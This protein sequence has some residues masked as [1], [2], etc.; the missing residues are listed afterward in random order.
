[1]TMRKFCVALLSAIIAASPLA[2]GRGA[3]GGGAPT[4]FSLPLL[5]AS[6]AAS[7]FTF[8]GSITIP[9]G[10]N[11]YYGGVVSPGGALSVSGTTAF[12][13][14]H[15]CNPTVQFCNSYA[16]GVAQMTLPAPCAGYSGGSACTATVVTPPQ[17]P[18]VTYIHDYTFTQ[19][20]VAGD[21][22][23]TFTSLPPNI[24]ANSGWYL[25]FNGTTTTDE[26]TAISGNT[27]TWATALPS[28]TYSTTI[29]VYQ[30]SPTEP[31]CNPG[32]NCAITGS[33][34]VN[35]TLYVTGAATYDLGSGTA[36]WVVQSS[37]PISGS[38]WGAIN[39]PLVG[40][41][42][43]AIYSRYLAGPLYQTPSIWQPYFGQDYST[44]GNGLSI[45]SEDVPQGPSY[46]AFN[47][48]DITSAGANT[49]I[50]SVLL[51]NIG[52]NT[53]TN[54]SYSGPFPTCTQS[55][56]C[57]PSASGYPITLSSTPAAGDTSETIALPTATVTATANISSATDAPN[58]TITAITAGT[59]SDSAIRYTVTDT[60]GVL[61][62]GT[63]A[64]PSYNYAPGTTLGTGTY[65][66]G[67]PTAAATSDTLT[68]TPDG[69]NNTVGGQTTG[70]S[71]WTITFS[72]GERR[73]GTI[74]S[75]TI[76]FSP[77]LT[78]T[79]SQ[80]AEIAPM[81]DAWNTDYDGPSGTGFWV[82]GTSTFLAM[83]YHHE[84][85]LLPRTA[86]DPCAGASASESFYA[87]A[88]DTGQNSQVVMLLYSASDLYKQVTNPSTYPP[89]TAKPYATVEFPDN[90]HLFSSNG[91]VPNNLQY[92]NSW[93]SFDPSDDKFYAATNGSDIFEY[94]V[95][96]P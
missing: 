65:S 46:Q 14:G 59:L 72:D 26:V 78:G 22:Q 39:I 42:A 34:V 10:T 57:S 90:S 83:Y 61:P 86:A 67:T 33:M 20:P 52:N 29:P 3:R 62:S 96:P 4:P 85:P 40:G 94:T 8:D 18:G 60:A 21:T 73:V 36:G 66:I 1:M 55:E 41:T 12:I 89:Y 92:Q 54:S 87:L 56:T 44:N 28:G 25:D 30:F 71:V 75:S 47:T 45:V 15:A 80:S 88:P 7:M 50:T 31:W 43:N 64:I 74:S 17:V 76:T 58:V 95:T 68:F 37:L 84:G 32:N 13:N 53:L 79:P 9:T 5:T 69:Y 51:Y 11:T 16:L 49:P 23:A 77:A 6:Q 70:E 27:V 81:G 82:P 91:C 24:A 19:A 35:N 93:A 63:L 38:S 48:A 2:F